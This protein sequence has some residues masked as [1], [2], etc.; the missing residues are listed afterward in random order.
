M[1]VVW[2][3]DALTN[4]RATER[5]SVRMTAAMAAMVSEENL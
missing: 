1:V 2:G 3:E 5:A 4:Q